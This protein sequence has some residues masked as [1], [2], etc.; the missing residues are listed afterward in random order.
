MIDKILKIVF[1]IVVAAYIAMFWLSA[2]LSMDDLYAEEDE[3]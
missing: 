2:A 3:W 1:G